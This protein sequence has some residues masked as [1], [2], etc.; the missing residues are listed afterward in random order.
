[1]NAAGTA[2]D[3]NSEF[4]LVGK[5]STYANIGNPNVIPPLGGPYSAVDANGNTGAWSTTHLFATPPDQAQLINPGGTLT[6]LPV[7]PVTFSWHAV[8]GAVQ[9]ELW[10]NQINAAGP[11]QRVL[12]QPNLTATQHTSS[13]AFGTG[14][15]RFWVRAIGANGRFGEWSSPLS[16][17]VAAV[18]AGGNEPN[19]L[20]VRQ[21]QLAVLQ[22]VPSDVHEQEPPV[23]EKPVAV[24][25]SNGTSNRSQCDFTTR[26][27]VRRTKLVADRTAAESLSQQRAPVQSRNSKSASVPES[28]LDVLFASTEL[29][30]GESQD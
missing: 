19:P 1:M 16:F 12:H 26:F 17:V 4:V 8:N 9:Y 7:G 23:N 21:I 6:S 24:D 10:V 3:P 18:D 15:Y 29:V 28:T 27:D 11:S 2:V 25:D 20:E 13:S 14:E 30:F 22:Q 5:N